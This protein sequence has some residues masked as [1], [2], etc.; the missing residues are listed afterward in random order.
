MS[1]KVGWLPLV[2]AILLFLALIG[3]IIIFRKSRTIILPTRQKWEIHAQVQLKGGEHGQSQ[4][5][6]IVDRR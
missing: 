6:F 1:K 2:G 3:L 4:E 5:S